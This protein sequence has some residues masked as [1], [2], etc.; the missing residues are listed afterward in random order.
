MTRG[1]RYDVIVV[2][3]RCAG[4]TLATYLARAGASVLVVDR[5]ALPSDQVI[6]THVVHAAGM[7][8]LDEVDFFCPAG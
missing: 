8:V 7:D 3:A 2:G 1:D 4:A 6:S 5:D